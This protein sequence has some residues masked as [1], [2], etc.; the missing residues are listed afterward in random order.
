MAETRMNDQQAINI[1]LSY[2]GQIAGG[3]SR[4]E[5]Q[6]AIDQLANSAAT[7]EACTD[8]PARTVDVSK[9]GLLALLSRAEGLLRENATTTFD[10]YS[11]DGVANFEGD[12]EAKDWYD[13]NLGTAD[14]LAAVVNA[15]ASL[16]PAACDP[17]SSR[18]TGGQG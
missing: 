16:L 13:S 5:F 4:D 3:G 12:P 9:P 18:D 6:Q 17:P 11:V 7:R 15:L 8:F 14:A 10:S 2:K 1:L